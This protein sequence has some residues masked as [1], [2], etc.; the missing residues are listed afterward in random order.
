LGVAQT[1]TAVKTFSSA[2]VFNALPTGTAVASAATVSTIATR[3]ANGILNA[4][5]F[6]RANQAI[7]VTTNAG[8]ADIN[9]GLQT[10]TNSS[11]A[12]M[13]ITLTT[14]SAVDGQMKLIRIYDFSAVAEGITWVNTEN[15]TVTAPATSNGSTSLPLTVGFIYNGSTSKWRCIAVA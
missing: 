12:A 15:S 5:L 10:F 7:T 8:T 11:A 14:T 1:F 13:T 4:T 6:G 2:P 9:H 3:D